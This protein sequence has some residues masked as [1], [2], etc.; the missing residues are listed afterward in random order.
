MSRVRVLSRASPYLLWLVCS[1]LLRLCIALQNKTVESEKAY[2]DLMKLAET[3]VTEAQ[4]K[5]TDAQRA[6]QQQQ[7]A[8]PQNY[9]AASGVSTAAGRHSGYL[10]PQGMAMQVCAGCFVIPALLV[11]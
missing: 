7:R 4:A 10:A 6:L 3:K 1:S 2:E 9:Q 8:A 5:H 11:A